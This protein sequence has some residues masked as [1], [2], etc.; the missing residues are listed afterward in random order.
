MTKSTRRLSRWEGLTDS[1]A[2]VATRL[3]SAWLVRWFG[4]RLPVAGIT[5]R[6]T[7][8]NIA[9]LRSRWAQ[10]GAGRRQRGEP[11]GPNLTEPLLGMGGALAGMLASPINSMLL[12]AIMSNFVDGVWSRIGV[13]LNWL[14]GGAPLSALLLA[15]GPLAALGLPAMAIGG[16]L[17]DE[18][19]VLGAMAEVAAPLQRLWDQLTGS[20][21]RVPNPLLRQLL[22]LADRLPVLLAQVL[23]LVA[24]VV[25]R[26]A[27]LGAPFR[28]AV[29]ATVL[30]AQELIGAVVLVL[31]DTF[32]ALS[33]LWTGPG[34]VPS[35]LGG[36]IVVVGRLFKTVGAVFREW[37][38]GATA[39]LTAGLP[40]ARS[41]VA[42]WLKDVRTFV[43]AAVVEHPTVAWL[44]SFLGSATAFSAW[45]ARTGSSSSSSPS[46][47]PPG[48]MT[49]LLRATGMPGAP[50][51]RP[52]PGP[53]PILL[54]ID[55][56]PL[57]AGVARG[58]GLGA[59]SDPFALDPAQ[60]AALVRYRTRPSVFGGQW[61][62]LRRRAEEPEAVTRVMALA[63]ALQRVAPIV[64]RGAGAG[65]GRHAAEFLP[66]LEAKLAELDAAVRPERVQHPTRALEEPREIR[67]VIRR[68][69][70]RTDAGEASRPAVEAFVQSLRRQL[71]LEPYAVAAGA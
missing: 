61:A 69:R 37:W 38:A 68:L 50:P 27:P 41:A 42:V 7:I 24:V 1:F 43:R 51:P 31:D 62:E 56:V 20:R 44:R 70:V 14:S 10:I 30:A 13:A 4:T 48:L 34:S 39:T 23:G 32:V 19:D 6:I 33:M 2:L 5:L 22:V 64:A 3:R 18:H 12:T 47:S 35:V 66:R 53:L 36:V 57:A 16:R 63:D 71:D 65:A 8:V 59:S 49:R 25:T 29:V 11:I 21:S 15:G 40:A 26:I 45:R 54:P 67:P 9:A 17:S 60:R 28:D 58:L 52:A 55:A 46:S